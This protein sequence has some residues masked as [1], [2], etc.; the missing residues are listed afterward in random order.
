MKWLPILLTS[1]LLAVPAW[2][3]SQRGMVDKIPTGDLPTCSTATPEL[4]GYRVYDTTADM[5]M[6]CSQNAATWIPSY[7]SEGTLAQDTVFFCG[8][9]GANTDEFFGG[10]GVPNFIGGVVDLTPGGAGC[11]ALG[12][13]AI[14]GV[15][16]PIDANQGYRVNGMFCQVT[17][18]PGAATTVVTFVDDTVDTLVTCSIAAT[19][20]SCFSAVGVSADVAAASAVAIST[21]NGTDDE[22]A[23]DFFC[24]VS[25]T[26]Q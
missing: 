10:P 14:A 2:G 5:E 23:Q 15:D 8:E 7:G 11:N 3:Q 1:L 19:E 12:N 18:A 20:L 13:T 24:R 4:Y 17:A 21:L 9:L 25:I 26:W 22:S 6:T 16:A